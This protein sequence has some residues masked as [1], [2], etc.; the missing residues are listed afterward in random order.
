MGR[1]E[2][3]PLMPALT[4]ASTGC[5]DP[6]IGGRGGGPVVPFA[7][8]PD[9]PAP[10]DAHQAAPR[11]GGGAVPRTPEREPLAAAVCEAVFRAQLRQPLVDQPRVPRYYLALQGHDP[12]EA[13]LR[14]LRELTPWV[15]P[16]SQCRVTA[17]D[18]VIDR[19]TGAGGVIVQVARLTWVHGAAADVVGGYYITQRHAAGLRYR[20]EQHGPDW[21]VTTIHLLWRA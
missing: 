8:N 6:R 7:H 1:N 16:L 11:R 2:D 3:C 12:D 9:G 21:A 20:V 13:L 5:P 15:Q 14:R 17:R 4:C 10:V 19:V 18:G